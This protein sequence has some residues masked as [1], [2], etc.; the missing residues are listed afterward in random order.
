MVFCFVFLGNYILVRRIS[1]KIVLNVV[2]A[3]KL[4]RMK[5]STAAYNLKIKISVGGIFKIFCICS[6]TNIAAT[7]NS[8]SLKRTI[9]EKNFTRRQE[10]SV[11]IGKC[12][13]KSSKTTLEPY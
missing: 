6:Y 13:Q 5:P 12:S 8:I 9:L 4:V 10:L 7:D 11:T 2:K 1:V 3:S